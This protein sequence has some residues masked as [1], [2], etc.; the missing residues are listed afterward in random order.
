MSSVNFKH[1]RSLV[2]QFKG[3]RILCIGDL[4]LDSFNHG[5][6]E[7]IS[8]ERPVPVF[9]PGQIIHVPGGSANVARNVSALGGL[10]SLVGLVGHDEASSILKDLLQQDQNLTLYIFQAENRP[11]SHKIR[12]T[13][14]GQHIMRLDSESILPISGAQLSDLLILMNELIPKHDVLIISDYA[15]GL[16]TPPLLHEIIQL[17]INHSIP[18]I[19]DPKSLEF[20][21]YYGAT[22]VTPNTAEAERA[23]GITI[24]RDDDAE[25]AGRKLLEKG[26]FA[27]VLIT[28]GPQGMS[29]I[30]SEGSPLHLESDA[31]EVFDVVGAGDT[32]IATLACM[33]AAGSSLF[34]SAACANVSAGIAVGKPDT[35]TVAPEVLIDRLDSLALGRIRQGAPIVLNQDDLVAF[36]AARRSEGKRIGFTNGVFDIVHPGHI[37]LLHFARDSCDVLIVGINSDE[38]VRRLNKG[39]ERPINS[40]QDRATVLGAFGM[41]DATVIFGEDTPINLIKMIKPEVLIKGADYSV[42]SVVGAQLVLSNGGEVLLAPIQEGK[43]ST[44][45]IQKVLKPFL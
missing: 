19:V 43:S 3:L 5:T 7:R 36:A 2:E 6:V 21:R 14:A 44:S 32:V 37:S 8:P 17:A 16:L 26:N 28:R 35:A 9:L 24:K 39:P 4:I 12:F 23:T 27:A 18:I 25:K 20:S 42:E 30:P 10:C 11:T 15:K 40:E 33:M 34:D 13:A 41:V 38:S 31:I 45:I 29:L 22:L 1:L